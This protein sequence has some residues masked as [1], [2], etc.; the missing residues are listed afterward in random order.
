M[1][2]V[3]GLFVFPFHFVLSH[4]AGWLGF[5]CTHIHTHNPLALSLPSLLLLPRLL[6]GLPLLLEPLLLLLQYMIKR[7]HRV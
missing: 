6:L 1:A 5:I 4:L 3:V 7:T 2:A